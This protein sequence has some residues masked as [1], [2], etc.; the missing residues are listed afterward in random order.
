MN[1]TLLTYILIVG[2]AAVAGASTGVVL[3]RTL[4]PIDEV[5]PEGFNP[6]EYMDDADEL[7]ANYETSTNKPAFIRNSKESDLVNIALA[8]YKRCENSFSFGIGDAD[9]GITVQSVRS[10]Q[11][12]RTQQDGSIRYFEEQISAG[13]IGVAKRSLQESGKDEVLVYTGYPSSAEV[14]SYADDAHTYTKEGYKEYLGKTLDE[15]FIYIIS[16]K[17]TL[18]SSRSTLDNGDLEIKLSLDTNIAT[19][20]YKAQMQHIS[21]LSNLPPFEDVN[22]TYTLSDDLVLKHMFV[23]ETYTATKEGIPVPAKTHN[24][25]HNYY[26]ADGVEDIPELNE[27]FDYTVRSETI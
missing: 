17:T 27:P 7:L 9:A 1:K 4:G 20:F 6:K 3:K 2:I 15:M 16:K 5:Y 14:A 13:M 12:K 8:K 18:K 11:V 25:I 19:Y 24:L 22:L 23:D 26:Y 21:G 10:A